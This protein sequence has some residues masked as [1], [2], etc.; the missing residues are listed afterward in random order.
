M[1]D[2]AKLVQ[3]EFINAWNTHNA[4]GVL[5]MLADD[6]VVT[7]DPPFP[8]APAVFNGKA[9]LPGFV[10]G[11]IAGIRVDT[12]NYRVDGDQVYFDATVAADAVRQLGVAA[13]EQSDIITVRGGQVAAFT[14]HL[15]P[16]SAA[17]LEAGA[18][19]LMAAPGGL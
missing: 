16:D 1:N 3:D 19:K 9:E 2:L 10:G 18:A 14:I 17:Q 13:V 11:F 7:L 15:S 4:E 8:G 12:R 6:A 5:K